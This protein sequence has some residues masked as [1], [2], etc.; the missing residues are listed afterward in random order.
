MS[1]IRVALPGYD[2]LTD[3]DPQHFSLFS[4]TDNVL[5]KEFDRGSGN[6]NATI[7]H[8]LGYVPFFLVYTDIGGG[9]FRVVNAQNPLG[10]GPQVYTTTTDLIIA[11]NAGADYQ[12][13]I[14]YDNVV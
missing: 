6:G 4:D 1:V 7:N 11:N 10:G 14:F 8:N 3:T 2:A 9:R 13:Y 12:Y 5:I